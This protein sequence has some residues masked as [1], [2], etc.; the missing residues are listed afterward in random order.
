MVI[1]WQC[2]YYMYSIETN[3]R[4]NLG[5]ID[6]NISM[7]QIAKFRSWIYPSTIKYKWLFFTSYRE[8]ITMMDRNYFAQY[9]AAKRHP[10]I[11]ATLWGDGF[12]G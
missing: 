7:E 4:F 2:I 6:Y 8:Y 12:S 10:N 11:N 1:L 5:L 9:Y 3:A